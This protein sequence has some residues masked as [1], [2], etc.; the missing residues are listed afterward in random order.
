[1]CLYQDEAG[2]AAIMAVELDDSLG[3]APVQYREVQ[4]HESQLFLS[5]FKSGMKIRKELRVHLIY[6]HEVH[7]SNS[8]FANFY[9]FP[10]YV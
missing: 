10:Y 3:G 2:A 1:M 5:Y 9:D 4:E 7:A 6:T 8:A